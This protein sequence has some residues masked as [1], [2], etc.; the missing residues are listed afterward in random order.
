[1]ELCVLQP[2]DTLYDITLAH[3]LSMGQF[4]SDNGSNCHKA[5]VGQVFLVQKGLS[6]HMVRQGETLDAIAGQH[7]LSPDRL[8]WLNPGV[9][10][11]FPGQKLITEREQH[12]NRPALVWVEHSLPVLPLLSPEERTGR[13]YEKLD[14]RQEAQQADAV[15][16]RTPEACRPAPLPRLRARLEAALKL[17]PREKA[18]LELD[19]LGRDRVISG[20]GTAL[21][22]AEEAEKL[23]AEQNAAIRFHPGSVLARFRYSDG[24]GREHEVQFPD[25]RALEAQLKLV[26]E[27]RLHGI[28]LP[29]PTPAALLLLN[30]HFDLEKSAL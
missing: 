11:V 23:A 9:H 1:M 26:R 21:L 30:F 4:L 16:L 10:C 22:T 14:F 17:I 28:A 24:Q 15:L 19:G 20:H 5:A 27:F 3:R 7:H 12:E 13:K 6:F 2:G 25:L 18:V 29:H 8:R